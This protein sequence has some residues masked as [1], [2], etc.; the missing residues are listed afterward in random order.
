MISKRNL[1]I[2]AIVALL[3][4]IVG[5]CSSGVTLEELGQ[6]S[7][8][9]KMGVTK[10]NIKLPDDLKEI[11]L[12]NLL[13]GFANLK[14]LELSS[15]FKGRVV[16]GSLGRSCCPNL[17]VFRAKGVTMLGDAL[18]NNRDGS[19]N[20]RE[21]NC[22]S[23][24]QFDI[25]CLGSCSENKIETLDLPSFRYVGGWEFVGC[26]YLKELKLGSDDP[27]SAD[28][29]AFISTFE[30]CNTEYVIL[31]L[32]E[33]EYNNHVE[34]NVWH[35]YGYPINCS[36]RDVDLDSPEIIKFTDWDSPRHTGDVVFKE[37]RRY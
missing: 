7:A 11:N 12:S 17:E 20:L 24:F 21:I 33:F 13:R 18:F 22:P 31:Y 2:T 1:V 37:I 30:K 23:A 6:M 29:C 5:S 27:I 8:A 15:N 10:L 34:G 19:K 28:P 36:S 9:E 26:D 16:G 4:I 3:A 25:H 32:G 35:M 14:E